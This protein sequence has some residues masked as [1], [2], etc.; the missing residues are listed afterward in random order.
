M[1]AIKRIPLEDRAIDIKWENKIEV[2]SQDDAWSDGFKPPSSYYVTN[3]WGD[4]VFIRTNKR[5]NAQK[6]AD[7]IWGKNHFRVKRV[8]RASVS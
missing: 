7:E 3:G 1:S 6:I 2:Y 8:L 4:S 5:A